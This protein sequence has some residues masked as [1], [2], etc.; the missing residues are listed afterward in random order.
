M[1][2]GVGEIIGKGLNKINLLKVLTIIYCRLSWMF[3][4]RIL[5]SCRHVFLNLIFSDN[6]HI[7][8][9][10]CIY[11]IYMYM[12]VLFI[13]RIG[14]VMVSMLASSV[15][16]CGFE[17]LSVQAKDYKIGICCFSAKHIALRRKSN[18]WLAQNQNNMS[19]WVNMSIHRTLFQ[20]ASSIKIQLNV[21]V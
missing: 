6:M 17:S 4:F 12:Y 15:V 11:G 13:Y 10:Y 8:Q 19:E 21:L 3:D 20:W 9:M 2:I 18:D 14:G 5:K 16:D 1:F 7:Q